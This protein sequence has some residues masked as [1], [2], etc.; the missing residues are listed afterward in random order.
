VRKSSLRTR[1][2]SSSPSPMRL[3][4]VCDK[5]N[6]GT[7]SISLRFSTVLL[8][9]LTG[10]STLPFALLPFSRAGFF[11]HNLFLPPL[12]FLVAYLSRSLVQSLRLSTSSS[13]CAFGLAVSFAD[14]TVRR[15]CGSLSLVPPVEALCHGPLRLVFPPLP[16]NCDSTVCV[17][18]FFADVGTINPELIF[19]FESHPHRV[20]RAASWGP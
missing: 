19:F 2:A 6:F 18:F 4:W 16:E 8:Q 5:P 3:I 9:G 20:C 1:F 10:L 13:P 12:L 7:S 11:L 14:R 17:F 15:I